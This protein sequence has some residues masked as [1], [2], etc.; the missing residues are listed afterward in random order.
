M[1]KKNRCGRES[2]IAKQQLPGSTFCYK[3]DIN[4]LVAIKVGDDGN[5]CCTCKACPLS[6]K[7]IP[8]VI[9]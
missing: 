2:R 8:Q 1:A 9:H 5:N 6:G 3:S 4:R 7:P